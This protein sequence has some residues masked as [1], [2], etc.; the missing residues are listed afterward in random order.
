MR[1]IYLIY[2]FLFCT[3][4]AS[5]LLY[6]KPATWKSTATDQGFVALMTGMISSAA[7]TLPVERNTVR[8]ADKTATS[9]NAGAVAMAMPVADK[10]VPVVLTAETRQQ[11]REL[12]FIAAS[13][14]EAGDRASAIREL[15]VATPDSLIALQQ[16]V[17]TDQLPRNRLLAVSSVRQLGLQ[18]DTDGTI[19]ALLREASSDSDENVA[20]NARDALQE[21]EQLF[22]KS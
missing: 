20:N 14:E 5:S 10:K 9:Q 1:R 18:G 4:Y 13:A 17:R 21:L 16:V 3:A 22:G 6:L 12:S 2:I 11:I 8:D 7:T 19:R 15:N